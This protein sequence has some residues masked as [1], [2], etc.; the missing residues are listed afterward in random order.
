MEIKELEDKIS[1]YENRLVGIAEA[2]WYELLMNHTLI[3]KETGTL[4]SWGT[5]S[6]RD[7]N[8]LAYASVVQTTH[9]NLAFMNPPK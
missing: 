7:R 2:A 9:N 1:E 4:A 3:H 8:M 5:N 6:I